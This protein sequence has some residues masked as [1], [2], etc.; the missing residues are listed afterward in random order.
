MPNAYDSWR[1]GIQ[2]DN[3]YPV[4]SIYMSIN[5]TNPHDLFGGTWEALDGG[6]FLISQNST[7]TA[8]SIGGSATIPAHNHTIAAQTSG[9]TTLTTAQMPAHTHTRGTMEIAGQMTSL[10][11][12]QEIGIFTMS[13][14]GAFYNVYNKPSG[15]L[16]GEDTYWA[17]GKDNSSLL[18]FQASRNWTGATSS[19][20]GDGGHSHSIPA[21]TTADAVA[22]TNLPPYLSVYMWKRIS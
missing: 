3:I 13:T 21:T 6:K 7:Y 15:R 16:T 17:S 9:S 22:Q 4:G 10:R 19:V 12:N 14:S 2:I 5:S 1:T 8:G 11:W 18:G 20:G